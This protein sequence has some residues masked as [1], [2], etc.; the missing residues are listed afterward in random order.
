MIK[1]IKR[2]RMVIHLYLD[3]KLFN[4]NL[5]KLR[6]SEPLYNKYKCLSVML[7]CKIKLER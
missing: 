7:K 4:Q 1:N 2:R 5:K 3:L 6:T